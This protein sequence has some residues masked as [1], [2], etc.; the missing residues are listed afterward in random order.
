MVLGDN[1]AVMS[2]S[3]QIRYH[4][5]RT[6]HNWHMPNDYYTVTFQFGANLTLSEGATENEQFNT[7]VIN[8]NTWDLL[9]GTPVANNM[10]GWTHKL[11]WLSDQLYSAAQKNSTW[12]IVTGHHPVISTGPEGEQ[13][14]LQYVLDLYRNGHPR[15]ME[16]RLVQLLFLHYQVDAY[17]SS[18]DYLMEYVALKD[19]DNDVTVSF[20]SSGAGARLLDYHLGQG[21][22]GRLRGALYPALCWAGRK[23]LFS[24][25]PGGCSP[26]WRDRDQPM[27]PSVHVERAYSTYFGHTHLSRF[28]STLRE[29]REGLDWIHKQVAFLSLEDVKKLQEKNLRDIQEEEFVPSSELDLEW[30]G[31]DATF[32]KATGVKS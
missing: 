9:A 14:R 7:T 8:L 13:A 29:I 19:K 18:H 5:T 17:I 25:N 11:H 12:L 4:Y 28:K 6:H 3:T 22:V 23:I 16:S 10:E 27:R 32:G 20:I 2:P 30:S 26:L 21:W 24:L 31:E 1:D 15:G